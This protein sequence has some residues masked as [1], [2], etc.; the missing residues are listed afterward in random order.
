MD[1]NKLVHQNQTIKIIPSLEDSLRGLGL[2]SDLDEETEIW[3]NQLKI[4][5]KTWKKSPTIERHFDSFFQFCQDPFRVALVCIVK[6][7]EPKDRKPKSLSYCI[8]EIIFKWSQTNGRLPEET[9]KLPAYNIATQQ[10]NQHFLYL[11]VKTY[12]LY[13]IK[14]TVLPL[15]KDMI[16]N[17]N[18]KQASQIVIAMELFDE[19]PVEDLLFP[20]VLQDTP[21]LIDEYLSESPNQIQPFLLFLDRLLDKNFSIRD[22]AQKFIEENKIYNVK[23]DK[24]H[25]KPLG[26]LVARLC[27]KFN[28]PIESCK[29]LSKNR[30]TGG[31]RYLIHQRY[32]EHNLSP[33]VWDDLVKDS[34]KQSTDCAKEF[35]D[36]LAMY[37]INESLKWSSYFEI[38]NDCLPHALQNLTIKDNP[39][40]EE[41]WD[42]TD[43]AAQNYYRLPISEENI[44]I[45][46]T[47][48]KFDELISKLSNCPIISFDCEWK[49]SFGAAKSRMALIQIGTFDQ[50]YLIDTLILNN[51]QYMGSWCRFNKYVLDNAEIIKLGFGVEQDLNEMKSLIIGLNNIKVKGEG[52]LDLGLLWKNLVKCGLSLPSNSDNGGNSLSSLVQTCFGL[53]LEKSEQCSNWELRPLRNTQIHY[54]A[55]DAF[56]LLEIY[57][58]LQNLCVEQH[59]NFEEICNDVMLDRKLKCLK[60]NKVVDC[61]QTTKNIKVRTPMD[62][63]ILLEHD[64]AHLRY[65]LR[66]CGI[67]TTITTSHM[68][69][70]DTIKLATSENRLILTSKLKFSP[71][72]RFSQ[73]FIL[74]IGKGSIKDQLLKILKH[75]N[76]GLQKN[77][78]LTRCIECNSTDVKYYSINDLKDICRKY[79]GGSHKSS[80]QIRRSASDNEDDNDY[81]ENFLS[82]SEGE[83]IHLYKPFPIQDKW[84]TSSSGAKINMNQIEKL[85][86]S[87]KTSHI[88]ENCGKLYCDEEPLLKSIHEVIMSITNFN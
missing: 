45:I 64:N 85:C 86:A 81:S 4:K 43:N 59:I 67:D 6:C 36:M 80:D 77:Y 57:K 53:P 2:N 84:Y 23:Y 41:N 33:S 73:N 12:Q 15:V 79:N 35:V 7:D 16:R 24:I 56:V 63:K 34:L 26:K 71:S 21:N 49:P 17:D 65:Y 74:D 31:L 87:N 50:V 18:C 10:R 69:W 30:T 32:V 62:V 54:A 70:H 55:L 83:D 39:I 40:E 20:L 72:S 1:L 76:V 58:Y 29:N 19:I 68:L 75:F 25:Y 38:S 88:C 48:E 37:D 3:F 22:Y 42:S 52:L 44:L 82:D 78:I 5:W 11:A 60:K 8:L 9:L 47:A 27:N 61:L 28:V 66:Y 46:D 14:E 51:K 13:T